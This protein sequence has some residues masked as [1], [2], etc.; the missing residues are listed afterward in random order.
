MKK[1]ALIVTIITFISCSKEK[2]SADSDYTRREFTET[3]MEGAKKQAAAQGVQ[4]EEADIKAFCDCSADKVLTE[5]NQEELIK[6]GLQEESMMH[7]AQ[8]LTQPCLEDFLNKL[9]EKLL[10]Q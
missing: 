7:K 4:L 8:E 10:Q 2:G 3:C 6:L 9:Q 5:L 1:I